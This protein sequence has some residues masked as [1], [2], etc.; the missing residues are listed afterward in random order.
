MGGEGGT[1]ERLAEA[2]A[3]FVPIAAGQFGYVH[4]SSVR[5]LNR[6]ATIADGL[7]A[8]DASGPLMARPARLRAAVTT[9]VLA[10]TAGGVVRARAAL[11]MSV[12]GRF[13][14][15]LARLSSLVLS[16]TDT[17]LQAR[18]SVVRGGRPGLPVDAGASAAAA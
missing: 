2:G 9:A 3:G 7:A 12:G 15:G 6:Y 13:D 1:G 4:R 17:R 10:G 8:V 16:V 18:A 14:I 5:A 11:G